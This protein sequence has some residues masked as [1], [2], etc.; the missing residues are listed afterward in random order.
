[1]AATADWPTGVDALPHNEATL[2]AAVALCD[3]ARCAAD[4]GDV[5]R[6]TA[7]RLEALGRLGQRL[8]D[9]LDLELA[10]G[11]LDGAAVAAIAGDLLDAV[12]GRPSTALAAYGALRPGE[13]LHHV[14]E[15][16]GGTWTPGTLH[17]DLA[18]EDGWLVLRWH[19][20]GPAVPTM[21]LRSDALLG[22]WTM[23]DEVEGDGYR[24]APVAVA[25]AGG[26]AVATCYVAADTAPR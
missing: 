11:R 20:R 15:P 13:S 21:V 7:L 23:L 4:D 5:Q 9:L 22:A 1:M 3:A 24:R 6:A 25:V 2:L 17:G 16:L 10:P 26:L 18:V 12:L 14:V 19:H 8:P